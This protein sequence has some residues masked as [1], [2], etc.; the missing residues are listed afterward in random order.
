VRAAHALSV[1]A[2]LLALALSLTLSGGCGGAQRT[3]GNRYEDGLRAAGFTIDTGY[4]AAAV[5]C[6]LAAGRAE[7]SADLSAVQE[8]CERAF[9]SFE[10]AR[11]SHS[12]AVQHLASVGDG[13]DPKYIELAMRVFVAASQVWGI[14]SELRKDLGSP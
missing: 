3:E 10:I 4:G 9:A 14:V 11:V 7:T 1:V 12:L 5:A 6:D 2:F 13:T 8:R